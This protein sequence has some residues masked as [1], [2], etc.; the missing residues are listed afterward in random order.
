MLLIVD[1]KYQVA[2]TLG[3]QIREIKT[4]EKLCN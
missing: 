4:G 3:D 1:Y 2:L